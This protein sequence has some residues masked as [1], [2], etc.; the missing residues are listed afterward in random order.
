MRRALLP[1]AAVLITAVLSGCS[2]QGLKNTQILDVDSTLKVDP[3]G[4]FT[5][6]G[7]WDLKYTFDCSNQQSQ[8]LLNANQVALTVFNSDDDS[9]NSEH[10]TAGAKGRSGGTTLHFTRGGTFYVLVETVCSWRVVVLD[11]NGV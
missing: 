4:S 11:L 2:G 5:V 8:R 1:I 7:A 9:L 10:A 3:T 6:A